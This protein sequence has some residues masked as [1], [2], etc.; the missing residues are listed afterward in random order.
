MEVPLELSP[1]DRVLGRIRPAGQR[2]GTVLRLAKR[3]LKRRECRTVQNHGLIELLD[4]PLE[5][6]GGK[7]LPGLT[8][9]P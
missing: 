8:L 5:H 4:Q 2:C 7:T 6:L 9:D 3:L 1:Q